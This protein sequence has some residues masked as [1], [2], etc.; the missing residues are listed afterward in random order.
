MFFCTSYIRGSIGKGPRS[1]GEKFQIYG[2]IFTG[3]NNDC[4]IFVKTKHGGTQDRLARRKGP[5]EDS[6][7]WH[8]ASQGAGPWEE[9]NV[10]TPRPR[11]S[12]LW[13]CEEMNF[14]YLT[15]SPQN[16]SSF[17]YVVSLHLL[18]RYVL[19]A[20]AGRVLIQVLRLQRT[21]E[22]KAPGRSG[23]TRGR[24]VAAAGRH[25][26]WGG[27]PALC[28][29]GY[30]AGHFR[31]MGREGSPEK[32]GGGGGGPGGARPG[33]QLLFFSCDT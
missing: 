22:A 32:T 6:E 10:R 29:S 19:S 5:C 17:I 33:S 3:T 8:S 12:S 23:G 21:W 9:P 27:A 25:R 7:R 4:P 13:N 26:L 31:C 28:R 11:T 2:Y 16:V 24:V 30:G 14:C 15:P 20:S 18:S 1:C